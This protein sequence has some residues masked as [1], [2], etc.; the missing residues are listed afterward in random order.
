LEERIKGIEK[1]MS[2]LEEW[3]RGEWVKSSEGEEEG[4]SNSVGNRT[5][6]IV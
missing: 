2:R 4:D 1:E 6:S 5:R 3:V